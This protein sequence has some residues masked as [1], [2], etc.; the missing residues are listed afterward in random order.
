METEL[1]HLPSA[2]LADRISELSAEDG[3]LLEKALKAATDVPAGTSSD[4]PS[5]RRADALERICDG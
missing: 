3:A 5:Q 4:T 2:E 1:Q